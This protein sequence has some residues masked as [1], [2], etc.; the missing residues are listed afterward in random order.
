MRTIDAV[1]V[2]KELADDDLK[3]IANA[4]ERIALLKNEREQ[5][6]SAEVAWLKAKR[7][8]PC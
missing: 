5:D 6:R 4:A 8:E 7:D 3:R 1:W 2:G